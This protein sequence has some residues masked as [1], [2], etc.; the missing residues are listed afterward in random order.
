MCGR[1]ATHF[2]TF[3][4][5]IIPTLLTLASFDLSTDLLLCTFFQFGAAT[6]LTLASF[7]LS[8]DLLLCVFFQFGPQCSRIGSSTQTTGWSASEHP[9]HRPTGQSREVLLLTVRNF[10]SEPLG[11]VGKWR[12][13]SVYSTLRPQKNLRASLYLLRQHV[14]CISAPQN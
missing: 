9:A 7:D 10:L 1:F 14:Q 3:H 13:F 5:L 8:T 12:I 6:L 11:T 2:L 4:V